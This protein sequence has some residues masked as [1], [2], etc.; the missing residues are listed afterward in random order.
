MPVISAAAAEP[1]QL[2]QFSVY[3]E[4]EKIATTS[5]TC[6]A[7]SET[8]NSS[9]KPTT[10]SH[11]RLRRAIIQAIVDDDRLTTRRSRVLEKSAAAAANFSTRKSVIAPRVRQRE[12]LLWFNR[13]TNGNGPSERTDEQHIGQRF[14]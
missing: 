11:R 9:L 4:T 7:T 6:V 2:T 1:W 14:R 8:L 12:T 3:L 13:A 10:A 5:P